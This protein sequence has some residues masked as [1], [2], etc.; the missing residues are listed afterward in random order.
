[1]FGVLLLRYPH[2]ASIYPFWVLVLPE[3]VYLVSGW[4][5]SYVWSGGRGFHPRDWTPSEV[6]GLREVVS[7]LFVGQ[8][9]E[10]IPLLLRHLR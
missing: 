8:R 3:S 6:E 9:M 10:G 7:E 1:M 2:S 5:F 4:C